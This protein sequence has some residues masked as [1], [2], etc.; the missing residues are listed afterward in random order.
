MLKL[1]KQIQFNQNDNK[2]KIVAD[3]KKAIEIFNS[4]KSK[5]LKFLLK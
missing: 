1:I 4:N 3:T 5:N 2:M